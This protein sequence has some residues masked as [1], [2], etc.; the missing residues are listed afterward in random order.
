[1]KPAEV[2][3]VR[4]NSSTTQN[5]ATDKPIFS[6]CLVTGDERLD[7]NPTVGANKLR[8]LCRRTRNR[9]HAIAVNLTIEEKAPN[10]NHILI[11]N[12]PSQ[13]VKRGSL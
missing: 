4:L 11:V 1:M 6:G 13:V 8:C 7:I 5:R 2:G 3:R 10:R 12:R 9:D